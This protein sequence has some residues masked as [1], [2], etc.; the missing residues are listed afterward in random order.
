MTKF[1]AKTTPLA[2]LIAAT[3]IGSAAHA[4]SVC[5]ARDSIISQLKQ[6][7][8]ETRQSLGLQQ[9]RGVVEIFASVETGSWTILVTDTRGHSCLMAAG[10]AFEADKVA[11]TD[12]PT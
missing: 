1:F 9:G 4:Q 5:G 3:T 6:K 11:K 7:Y 8:G 12:T 10:E 2:L